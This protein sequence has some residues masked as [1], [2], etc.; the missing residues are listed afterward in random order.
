MVLVYVACA[1]ITIDTCI[2]GTKDLRPVPGDMW[3]HNVTGT[4]IR[5]RTADYCEVCVRYLIPDDE[6][7]LYWTRL[8]WYAWAM[9]A[10]K[11][12]DAE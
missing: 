8:E 2:R 4:K 5:V 3:Q 7:S 1:F 6:Y 11:V 9:F 12:N 10:R